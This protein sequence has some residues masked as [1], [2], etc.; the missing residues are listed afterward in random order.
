MSKK[1][2]ILSGKQFSGKDTVAKFLLEYLTNYKRIGLGDAIKLEYSRRKGLTIEEIETNKSQY[3]GDLIALGDWGRMQDPDYWLKRIIEQNDNVIVPDI[4]MPHELEVF[5]ANGA[6]T[7]RVEAPR[8]NRA[9][10]GVLVKE[11]DPTETLLDNIKEWDF[12]IQNDGTLE[13]LKVKAL[14]IAKKL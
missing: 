14:E 6:T 2:I 3:R 5:K 7:I 8:D 4:R 10:R 13:E 12:V 1:I 11:N 9:A